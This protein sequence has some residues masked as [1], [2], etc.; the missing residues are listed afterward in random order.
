MSEK[1]IEEQIAEAVES[2]TKGLKAK[3]DELLG[4]VKTLR[5]GATITPEKLAAVE[6]ER[7]ALK[8]Q[9][10]EANRA[11]TKATKEAKTAT[12]ALATE[13][14]ANHSLLVDRG[15]TD[16]FVKA[17]VAP[18]FLDFVKAK[19]MPLAKV[20]EADGVRKAQVDGKDVDAFIGEWT[21]GDVAKH[22]IKAPA[23]NGGGAQGGSGAG[24]GKSMPKSQFDALTPR[25]RAARMAEGFTLTD[26]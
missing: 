10:D 5:K 22:F 12:E 3:N 17:G 18:E 11:V 6:E 25:D 13:Q 1:T 24:A 8:T 21:K 23:N 9:L 15:L 7:D 4:E 19:Y 20:V 16:A 2:A 26:S 14:Q